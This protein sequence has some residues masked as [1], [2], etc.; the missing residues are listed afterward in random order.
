MHFCSNVNP[1]NDR[2][3]KNR[4]SLPAPMDLYGRRMVVRPFELTHGPEVLEGQAHHPE[5]AEGESRP[6]PDLNSN[7]RDFD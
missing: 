5:P 6:P 7:A 2:T 4:L 3:M 1:E